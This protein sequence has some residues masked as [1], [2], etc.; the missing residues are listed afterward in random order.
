MI[1]GIIAVVLAL[2]VVV[3]ALTLSR[4]NKVAYQSMPEVKVNVNVSRKYE[5]TTPSFDDE[6]EDETNYFIEFLDEQQKKYRYSVDFSTYLDTDKGQYGTLTYKGNRYLSF[7][8]DP[9]LTNSN[10]TTHRYFFQSDQVTNSKFELFAELPSENISISA[11]EPIPITYNE[12]KKL[13]LEGNFS[14]DAFFGI[15]NEQGKTLQF[16]FD[17]SH[18]S[19]VIDVPDVKLK[20]SYQSVVHDISQILSYIDAFFNGMDIPKTFKMDFIKW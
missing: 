6:S 18:N 4:K 12:V 9:T 20:G 14:G 16:S 7:V 11:S 8:V 19:I 1:Y 10:R 5:S 15:D 3:L 17:L 13:Y 2:L